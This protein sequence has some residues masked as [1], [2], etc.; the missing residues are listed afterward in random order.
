M[1]PSTIDVDVDFD[2]EEKVYQVR[3]FLLNQVIDC[4]RTCWKDKLVDTK[5]S[6][7]LS[8]VEN[9][10]TRGL[11]SDCRTLTLIVDGMIL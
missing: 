4:W 11:M 9:L 2:G 7:I 8:F 6:D 3:R 1:Q 5:P 10:E